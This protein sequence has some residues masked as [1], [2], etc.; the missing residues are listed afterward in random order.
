MDPLHHTR[1]GQNQETTGE[2]PG[3]GT[4]EFTSQQH[5]SV[6]AG[7]RSLVASR[8][9]EPQLRA[10]GVPLRPCSCRDSPRFCVTSP[11]GSF[12][13]CYSLAPRGRGV[14]SVEPCLV[15]LRVVPGRTLALL[16]SR[17]L[18]ARARAPQGQR[19]AVRAGSGTT[20]HNG[21]FI[22][23]VHL[24]LADDVLGDQI[25]YP[26]TVLDIVQARLARGREVPPVVGAG[27]RQVPEDPAVVAPQERRL[28]RSWSRVR[29]P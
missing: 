26:L 24:V 27:P 16:P 3:S 9:L 13:L 2:A 15:Q 7:R 6:V 14:N 25:L 17:L 10:N 12:S 1:T 23:L 22:I 5:L 20:K 4:H 18:T 8:G 21:N 29:N 28:R 19:L 11:W